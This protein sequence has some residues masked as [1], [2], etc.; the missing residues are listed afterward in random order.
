MKCGILL[1]KLLCASYNWRMNLKLGINFQTL[2]Y[3][4]QNQTLFQIFTYLYIPF[5][6]NCSRATWP[7]GGQLQRQNWNSN[8]LKHTCLQTP[9]LLADHLSDVYLSNSSSNG[10]LFDSGLI[11]LLFFQLKK[12]KKNTPKVLINLN[13]RQ[14]WCKIYTTYLYKKLS[15][16][17]RNSR[18]IIFTV[19]FLAFV[20]IPVQSLN[21]KLNIQE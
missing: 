15:Y 13:P 3:V 20:F 17:T 4:N 19:N 18:W 8:Q 21:S 1:A 6:P 11:N 7:S 9:M 14:P 16:Y 10:H 2:K 5:F 12:W